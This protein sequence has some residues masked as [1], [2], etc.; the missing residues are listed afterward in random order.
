M[1]I[2]CIVDEEPEEESDS[3]LAPW[4]IALIVLIP[5]VALV[6][7]LCVGILFA[8]KVRSLPKDPG[9]LPADNNAATYRQQQYEHRGDQQQLTQ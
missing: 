2:Y 5:I 7:M 9:G 1:C 4:A 6:I 3:G 8:L